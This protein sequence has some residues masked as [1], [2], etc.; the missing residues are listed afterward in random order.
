MS[1]ST[2]NL[3]FMRSPMICRCG[4]P[5]PEST[6]SPVCASR[7]ILIVGSSSITWC[8]APPSRSRSAL[9]FA[10]ARVV[11]RRVRVQLA[12][13]D[14]QIRDLAV[15]IDQGL[16]DQCAQRLRDGRLE[17]DCLIAEQI[18]RGGGLARGRWNTIENAV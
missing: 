11:D 14:P 6:V 3:R 15:G 2:L 16:E 4:S 1:T 12:A 9:V 10:R 18:R 13:E 8:S 7:D 5:K 17:L